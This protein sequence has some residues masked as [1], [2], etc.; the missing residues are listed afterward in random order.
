MV[1]KRPGPGLDIQATQRSLS[2]EQEA[3]AWQGWEGRH[4]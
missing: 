1:K 2:P 4:V 3:R